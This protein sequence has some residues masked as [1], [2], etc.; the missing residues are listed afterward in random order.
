MIMWLDKFISSKVCFHFLTTSLEN[1][2]C[3]YCLFIQHKNCSWENKNRYTLSFL[4]LLIW[5]LVLQVLEVSLSPLGPTQCEVDQ[6][7]SDISDRLWYHE[8]WT[9]TGMHEQCSQPVN[10]H[11]VVYRVNNVVNFFSLCDKTDPS[12][13]L[14]CLLNTS[15]SGSEKRKMKRSAGGNVT[16][17]LQNVSWSV[18]HWELEVFRIP[19]WKHIPSKVSLWSVEITTEISEGHWWAKWNY[20]S[21]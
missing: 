21:D 16:S 6:S 5:F 19:A 14:V 8:A 15:S 20:Q 9:L 13:S 3:Q 4:E 11:T 1:D 7:F 2:H 10:T 17:C 12:K 18:L